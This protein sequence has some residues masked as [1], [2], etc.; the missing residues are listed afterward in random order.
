MKV[1]HYQHIAKQFC[2]KL[3]PLF[4]CAQLVTG[5]CDKCEVPSLN[6]A[7]QKKTREKKS[8]MCSRLLQPA[9]E[10][11]SPEETTDTESSRSVNLFL[12]MQQQC[13][14]LC[15]RRRS[16]Y[17]C[18]QM[19]HAQL[20]KQKLVNESAVKQW[21]F[22]KQQLQIANNKMRIFINLHSA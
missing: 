22:S 12:S 13:Y 9:T 5:F 18:K 11:I 16:G 1:Y 6:M 21:F 14:C 2:K 7:K 10:T 15:L 17:F 19:L 20:C 8:S 3:C 4:G